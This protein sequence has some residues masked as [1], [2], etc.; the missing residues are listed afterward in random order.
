MS[1]PKIAKAAITGNDKTAIIASVAIQEAYVSSA[2]V[3]AV[4]DNPRP[5]RLRSN[6]ERGQPL[7]ENGKGDDGKAWQ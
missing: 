5:V 1:W 4:D 6:G 3:S 2:E 7:Q